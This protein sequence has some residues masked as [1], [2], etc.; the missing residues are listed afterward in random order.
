MP[1]PVGIRVTGLKTMARDARNTV[2][3]LDKG[4][5]KANRRSV[6]RALVPRVRGG[7]PS[8][9]NRLASTVRARATA[10]RAQLIV[11]SNVKVPYAGPINFGWLARNIVGQEFIY[12]GIVSGNNAMLEIYIEEID[13]ATKSFAPLGKL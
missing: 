8:R 4:I 11:G 2:T 7:A 12:R 3:R 9:T 13:R 10:F 5:K 6:E 1:G